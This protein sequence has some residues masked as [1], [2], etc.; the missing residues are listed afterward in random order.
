MRYSE[1]NVDT[2]NRYIASVKLDEKEK[3][4][5]YINGFNPFAP[6]LKSGSPRSVN[7]LARTLIPKYLSS[8]QQ[9]RLLEINKTCPIYVAGRKFQEKHGISEA[10]FQNWIQLLCGYLDFPVILLLNPSRFDALEFGEM[11]PQSQTLL[12][13]KENLV[14]LKLEMRDVTVLD[15]FPMVTDELLASKK[16]VEDWSELVADSFELTWTCLRY[17]RPRILIS[18]QCCSKPVN[19]KWGLFGDIRATH[20]C[21]SEAAARQEQVKSVDVYGH[22]MPEI[23]LQQKVGNL[24]W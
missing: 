14:I 24:A 15:T 8:L 23:S 18:C 17:I 12:W 6:H 9:T 19:E 16:F 3:N 20:L 1:D 2:L 7:D 5:S 4:S 13:L 11:V 21:S 10:S 22:R